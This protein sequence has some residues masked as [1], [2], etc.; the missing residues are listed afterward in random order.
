MQQTPRW[1]RPCQKVWSC[2]IPKTNIAGTS[3]CCRGVARG[4]SKAHSQQLRRVSRGC[5]TH[6]SR[7]PRGLSGMRFNMA[8][9]PSVVCAFLWQ[10][11]MHQRNIFKGSVAEKY[12]E[13]FWVSVIQQSDLISQ[14]DANARCQR[15]R[16]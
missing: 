3:H 11:K 8:N 1:R 9:I 12:P 14:Y 15:R 6:P 2:N 7:L 16:N 10:H 13:C 4:N 5:L